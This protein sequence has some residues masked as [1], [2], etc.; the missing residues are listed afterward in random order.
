MRRILPRPWLSLVLLALWLLLAVSLAPGQWLL[1]AVFAVAL[2][3]APRRP[4][5]EPF[6]LDRPLSAL[7]LAIVVL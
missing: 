3:L 7:R 2:P 5:P 6:R 1:G 4:A